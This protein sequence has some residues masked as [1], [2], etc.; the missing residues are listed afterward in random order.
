[1]TAQTFGPIICWRETDTQTL[2]SLPNLLQKGEQ[3]GAQHCLFFFLKK[4]F[5]Y[6]ESRTIRGAFVEHESRTSAGQQSVT[7]LP[8][9][10][11]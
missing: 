6:A 10:Q 2:I 7:K 11:V 1:M 5:L 9:Y 4:V 8:Y 3:V